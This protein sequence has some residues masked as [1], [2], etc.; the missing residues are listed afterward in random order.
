MKLKG[1]KKLNSHMNKVLKPFGLKSALGKDFSY[2]VITEIVQYAIVV[3]EDQ[4]NFFSEFIEKNFD[5]KV[6]DIFLV[7]LLHEVGHHF[8]VDDFDD[9]EWGFDHTQKVFI[10]N[11]INEDNYREKSFEYFSLPTEFAA[12]AWAIEYLKNHEEEMYRRWNEMLQHI[13]HFYNRNGVIDD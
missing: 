4:N 1:V 10:E 2:N 12:T 11:S 3:D 8:T 6:T 13:Q 7:S 5:Y 9:A